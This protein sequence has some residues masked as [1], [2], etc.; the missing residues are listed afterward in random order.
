MNIK[1]EQ[2]IEVILHHLEYQNA[3]LIAM[4]GKLG[5]DLDEVVHP[6]ATMAPPTPA[7]KWLYDVDIRLAPPSTLVERSKNCIAALV[8]FSILNLGGRG[9]R[10]IASGLGERGIRRGVEV[11]PDSGV[12]PVHPMAYMPLTDLVACRKCG[13]PRCEAAYAKYSGSDWKGH[14]A[15]NL[16]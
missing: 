10:L 16:V 12:P 14:Q 8:H 1:A 5:M 13:Q 11:D 7:R 4:L 3:I 9:R 15:L 6:R 2:E